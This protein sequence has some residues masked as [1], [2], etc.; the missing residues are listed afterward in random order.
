MTAYTH[1]LEVALE[2]AAEGGALAMKHFGRDLDPQRKSDGSW[3]TEADKAVET[4]VRERLA[5]AFPDHNILGEEEGLKRADGGEPMSGAP[6]WVVDPIDGTNNFLNHVPIWGT[7]IALRVEDQSVVGVCH[8]PALGETY[9][10]AIGA[11]ARCNGA[12]IRADDKGRLEDS[13][14]AFASV[15]RFGERGLG[16]LFKALIARSWR[17]RGFGDFWGHMLVARGA[18]QVMIEPELSIWDVAALEP[19]VAEAG[20]RQTTLS[21]TRFFDGASCLTTNGSLHNEVLRL[22]K[23]Q[24]PDWTD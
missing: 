16:D 10:G 20:G 23:E 12:P 5:S 8:A 2:T 13:T 11:G 14:V 7:L 21:G 1:E 9:D 15:Q 18:V 6:T 3:V 19:I 22:V 24:A 17:S 4:L